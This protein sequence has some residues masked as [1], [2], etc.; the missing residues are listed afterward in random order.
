M[1]FAKRDWVPPKKAGED[2]WDVTS[3]LS[4]RSKRNAHRPA[5]VNRSTEK[6]I[7]EIGDLSDRWS[8]GAVCHVLVNSPGIMGSP[9]L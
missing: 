9:H 1:S 3:V 6:N 4:A 7:E 8:P 2:G 5:G